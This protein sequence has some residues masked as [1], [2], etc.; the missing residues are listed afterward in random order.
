[1][2]VLLVICLLMYTGCAMGTKERLNHNMKWNENQQKQL[3]T[4]VKKQESIALSDDI[5]DS[6]EIMVIPKGAFK[7]DA[8]GFEGEAAAVKIK[9]NRRQT[10]EMQKASLTKAAQNERLQLKKVGNTETRRQKVKDQWLINGLLLLCCMAVLM[11][12]YRGYKKW[13]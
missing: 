4:V 8:Q 5:R 7:L 12:A 6:V 13:A 1:M 10:R 9:A 3:A 2:K 11:L